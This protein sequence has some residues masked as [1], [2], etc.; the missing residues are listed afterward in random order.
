MTCV[1]KL[2]G[3]PDILLQHMLQFLTDS[4]N[5]KLGQEGLE[6]ITCPHLRGESSQ[7][8]ATGADWQGLRERHT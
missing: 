4:D 1:K 2:C 6:R 7:R 5:M 3:N 8:M